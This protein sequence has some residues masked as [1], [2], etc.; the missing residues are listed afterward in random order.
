MERSFPPRE[1]NSLSDYREL[2][3]SPLLREYMLCLWTQSIAG[4][5]EYNHCVLPDGCIDVV[6]VKDEPPVVVGP[7]TQSFIARFGPGTN[8]IGARF[9]PGRASALLG[10]PASVLLNQ[11]VPL[12]LICNKAIRAEFERVSDTGCGHAGL[13]ALET[14]LIASLPRAGSIDKMVREAI[15]WM[16]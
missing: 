13:S 6:F 11:S 16:A 14:A 1:T 4:S 8:I 15:Q 12:N 7:W 9:H 2:P 5:S 10:L 3:V